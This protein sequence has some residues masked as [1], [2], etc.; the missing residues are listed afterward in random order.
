[1]HFTILRAPEQD[2]GTST[3]E[4]ALVAFP[5]QALFEKKIDQFDLIILDGFKTMGLLPD[6]YM[7][8][9]VRLVQGGGGLLLL[10][11]RNSLKMAP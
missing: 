5:T 6:A 3:D 2:D 7:E 10:T 8:N 1:M 11:D 4:M 9:I